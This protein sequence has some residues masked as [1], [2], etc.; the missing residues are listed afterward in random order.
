L[1]GKLAPNTKGSMLQD[2]EN[3]RRTEIDVMCGAIIEAGQ[4]GGLATPFNQAML[5]LIKA[6]ETNYPKTG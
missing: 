3:R 1:L 2:V 5:W 4:R 6:L